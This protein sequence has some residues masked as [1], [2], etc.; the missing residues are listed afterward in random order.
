MEEALQRKLNKRNKKKGADSSDPAAPATKQ[1][2]GNP[3]PARE[4]P[5]DGPMQG[6][7]AA[8]ADS[9]ETGLCDSRAESSASEAKY[10]ENSLSSPPLTFQSSC[11]VVVD[12]QDKCD[13]AIQRDIDAMVERPPIP[14]SVGRSLFPPVLLLQLNGSVWRLRF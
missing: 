13:P 11:G 7:I 12:A 4:N 10:T 14:H 9:R 3:Q 6:M 2:S 1:D 5:E 8:S